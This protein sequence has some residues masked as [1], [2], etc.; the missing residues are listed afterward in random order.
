MFQSRLA[1]DLIWLAFLILLLAYFWKDRLALLKCRRWKMTQG[2][3]TRC[4]WTQDAHRIW[5]RIEYD[6]EVDGQTY[7]GEHLL[8]D[9]THHNP[10]SRFSK[11]IAYK[12]AIAY[13]NRQTID[14]YYNPANP[15]QSAL[16]IS[17][18]GKL[19]ALI[20]LLCGL[21]AFHLLIMVLT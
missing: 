4:E 14:V 8:A 20:A 10:A 13:Q 2:L 7:Q 17:M 3:I 19:T 1:M 6:F 15:E 5:P 21:I 9:T 18:P 16:D 12:A 11:R